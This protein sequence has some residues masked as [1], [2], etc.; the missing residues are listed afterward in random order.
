MSRTFHPFFGFLPG[1]ISWN[2]LANYCPKGECEQNIHIALQLTRCLVVEKYGMA[3]GTR[4]QRIQRVVELMSLKPFLLGLK[5]CLHISYTNCLTD[6][7]LLGHI[8]LGSVYHSWRWSDSPSR[9]SSC[10]QYQA[11][12]SPFFSTSG[13]FLW[14]ASGNCHDIG[15]SQLT[16]YI[17]SFCL[18]TDT[19]VMITL[20]EW[21]SGEL[22]AFHTL[23]TFAN[24]IS[25]CIKELIQKVNSFK[26]GRPTTWRQFSYSVHIGAVNQT[27]T[28][29]HPVLLEYLATER[30]VK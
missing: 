4:S 7:K 29:V 24:I 27:D 11:T 23:G 21:S 20:E 30:E 12:S 10:K 1:S 22:V 9:D 14:R 25:Q 13:E 8:W 15:V 3:N 26:E 19:Q 6:I 18:T 28:L 17:L 5:V 16:P 2:S